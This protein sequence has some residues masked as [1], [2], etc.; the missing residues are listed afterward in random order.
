MGCYPMRVTMH[1]DPYEISSS[2][3]S[4]HRVRGAFVNFIP[5]RGCDQ[6]KP[7]LPSSTRERNKGPEVADH[8]RRLRSLEVLLQ[9]TGSIAG[10]HAGGGC[11]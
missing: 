10:V 11:A 7:S 9:L 3:R 2:V 5:C 8:S 4:R 6:G 1:L